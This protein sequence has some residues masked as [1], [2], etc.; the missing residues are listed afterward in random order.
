MKRYMS[1]ADDK[2]S[3]PY[4]PD[5]WSSDA[6]TPTRQ[7]KGPNHRQDNG[8]NHQHS[9]H[10]QHPNNMDMLISIREN[11]RDSFVH[12]GRSHPS[13]QGL[14]MLI[15]ITI[16][17][18]RILYPKI[19]EQGKQ[20]SKVLWEAPIQVNQDKVSIIITIVIDKIIT[21]IMVTTKTISEVVML[22]MDSKDV[23]C[24]GKGITQMRDLIM[25]EGCIRATVIAI[26]KNGTMGIKDIMVINARIRS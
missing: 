3:L 25:D 19:T 5:H 13:Q 14:P 10:R 18:G 11:R 2:Q 26:T 21:T 6:V 8:N 24:I 4:G 12:S 23:I 7:D 1:D 17:G 15:S 22:G 9:Y 20:I 16:R